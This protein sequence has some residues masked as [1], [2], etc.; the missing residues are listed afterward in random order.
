[1]GK[2]GVIMSTLSDKDAT[3]RWNA[4]LWGHATNDQVYFP[5]LKL[6]THGTNSKGKDVQ[7]LTKAI[8]THGSKEL[9]PTY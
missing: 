3:Q 2:R 8:P 5:N 6:S 1:M 4:L 7:G 9:R